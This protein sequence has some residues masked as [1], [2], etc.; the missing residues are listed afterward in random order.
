MVNARLRKH[1]IYVSVGIGFNPAVLRIP[2][3]AI[4]QLLRIIIA[5]FQ[6]NMQFSR[7]AYAFKRKLRATIKLVKHAAFLRIPAKPWHVWILRLRNYV[8][9]RSRLF[10]NKVIRS[11]VW[12]WNNRAAS[13]L[14]YHVFRVSPHRIVASIVAYLYFPMPSCKRWSKICVTSLNHHRLITCCSISNTHKRRRHK[15][16]CNCHNCRKYCCNN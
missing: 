11:I 4:P 7:A 14:E 12:H 2:F 5:V 15:Y 9:F 16:C 10:A 8:K 13:Q 3:S 1:P 6:I